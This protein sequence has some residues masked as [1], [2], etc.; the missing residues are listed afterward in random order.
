MLQLYFSA[1]ILPKLHSN[2]NYLDHPNKVL[3][4][5]QKCEQHKMLSICKAKFS[6]MKVDSKVLLKSTSE[7]IKALLLGN[8]SL[9]FKRH[10]H[11]RQITKPTQAIFW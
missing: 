4:H 6:N 10:F 8:R 1:I 3:L 5:M 2:L 9:S 11:L 7:Y